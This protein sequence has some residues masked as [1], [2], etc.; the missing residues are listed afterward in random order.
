MLVGSVVNGLI[1]A[2]LTVIESLAAVGR[3]PDKN[4]ESVIV[5]DDIEQE[6]APLR[7]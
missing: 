5:L 2:L 6:G 4:D 3:A 1:K 7:D